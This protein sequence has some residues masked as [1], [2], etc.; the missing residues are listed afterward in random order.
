[1]L[2]TNIGEEWDDGNT[3]NGDGWS[4]L[5][6]IESGWTWRDS[7]SIW[8]IWG[9]GFVRNGEECD[10][11]NKNNG[12]GWSSFWTIEAGWTWSGSPSIWNRW[13]DSVIQG[14][15]QCDDGN[16]QNGDGWNSSCMIESGW[17]WRY[18]PSIWFMWGNGV[19]TNGEQ[20][21]DGNTNNGDG[22]SSSWIIETGWSWF[23]TP[24]I[25]NRWGDSKIEGREQ[26]DDGNTNSNDGC[27][28]SWV[29]EAGWN[30]TGTPSVW[31]R[32]V[33]SYCGD[34]KISNDEEWD[35]GNKSN[36]DGC[37]STCQIEP[38]YIW[39]N[40]PSN[41]VLVSELGG[42]AATIGKTTLY[43]IV[44]NLF[45]S[46]ISS[47]VFEGSAINMW[48]MLNM[49]QILHFVPMMTLYYPQV[50]LTMFS[51]IGLVNMNNLLL[52]ALFSLM[53][54]Q[55]E[56]SSKSGLDYRFDNQ[57]FSSTNIFMN[58][59]DTFAFVMIAFV[60]II[61]VTIL[62]LIFKQTQNDNPNQ[63][64]RKWSFESFKRLLRLMREAIFF[65]F[66]IRFGYESFLELGLAVFLNFY[67][68]SVDTVTEK[69]SIG[70]TL[71]WGLFLIWI[72]ITTLWV[73]VFIKPE[74]LEKQSVK[75]TIGSIY[76]GLKLSKF[77]PR[78]FQLIFLFRRTVIVVILVFL[79]NNGLAQL[80][81]FTWSNIVVIIHLIIF[82]PYESKIA[83]IHNVVNEFL[84]LTIC[85]VWFLFTNSKTELTTWTQY[86]RTAYIWISW[87]LGVVLLQIIAIVVTLIK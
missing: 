13:G 66:F 80:I 31:T 32:S 8:S 37:S 26:W 41:W 49:L 67:Q 77:G 61:T 17:T 45:A 57:S 39:E 42:T 54:N 44:V 69:E 82:R 43:S 7:P 27:N 46:V 28:S 48:A 25:W 47:F 68:P 4:S 5:W 70:A 11:G 79:W 55:S 1:M 74:T 73:S 38:G 58:S 63:K 22:W 14:N 53:I 2:Q 75:K 34:G 9:N 20:W 64:I 3:L 21:D 83:C 60:Y 87:C 6:M 19:I 76:S 84:L 30:W 12:D 51:Y 52:F 56:I 78:L 36:S 62:S 24:S 15:E 16:T 86:E 23:G 85:A 50:L 71:V 72:W 18:S 35:D 59:G 65:N 40:S 29:I 10:D 33:T 81:V